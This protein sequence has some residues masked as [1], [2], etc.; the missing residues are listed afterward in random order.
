MWGWGITAGEGGYHR[1]QRG[2]KVTRGKRVVPQE[3]R[4]EHYNMSAKY[5]VI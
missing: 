1:R 4:R 2:R 3:R 5:T